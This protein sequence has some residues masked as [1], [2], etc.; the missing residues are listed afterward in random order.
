MMNYLH[1]SNR[2]TIPAM[3]KTINAVVVAAVLLL[4]SLFV[5][6]QTNV[7]STGPQLEIIGGETYNWGSVKAPKSGALEG[8]IKMRNKGTGTLKLVEIKPGCGCTK[9]D[10]DKL[11]LGAG[12]ISTMKVKL[13]ISAAQTG[14]IVKSISVRWAGEKDTTSSFI[15]L[16][17]DIQRDI[18][19]S[20]N[21]YI[22]FEN[23]KVGEEA[24]ATVTITNTSGGELTL[25]E[26]SAENGL[27][28]NVSAPVV[29]Q[30]NATLDI[31]VKY[32]PTQKGSYNGGF[33]FKSS[34]PDTPEVD[35]RA[36]GNVEDL[37]SKVF[38]V[39]AN[40]K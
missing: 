35:I 7:A 4:S 23:L 19:V 5:D 30:P 2:S 10:P 9:T 29:L 8:E 1:F 38:Q 20:P 14:S 27:M 11:E 34:S 33:K 18:K 24:K 13:N 16:K 6:A 3:H 32:V 26:F 31:L 22:A 15:W 17:A 12:E 37:K 39:P 36:Y 28:L 21:P 25:R 40:G